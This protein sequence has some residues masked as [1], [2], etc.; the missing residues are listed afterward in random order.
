MVPHREF[1]LVFANG[2]IEDL[3]WVEPYLV[4]AKHVVAAN[5]G[6]LHPLALGHLPDGLIGDLDSLPEGVAEALVNW[7]IEVVRFLPAKDET[8][9]ELALL[10]AA[11]RFPNDDLIILG[12][13]GGR[14]DHML[15]N[16]L[17][18]AHPALSGHP[19]YLVEERQ[20]AWLITG[21]TIISG[22]PGDTVSLISLGGDVVV[23]ET[24][25][26]RWPL[27]DEVLAFGPA[28]GI[29]NEM[30]EEIAT[31]RLASGRLLCVHTASGQ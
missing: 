4:Q 28:R 8:D 20:K 1:V 19:I 25:G 30:T 27:I 21:E 6:I 14:V 22:R 23:S 18:L 5:G 12:G 16:I 11:R 31:V 26:L 3:S 7:D 17:L 10:Y 29:S 2:I 13:F 15:A 9:L 24:T